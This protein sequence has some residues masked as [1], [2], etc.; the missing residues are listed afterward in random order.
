MAGFITK[1]LVFLVAIWSGLYLVSRTV[2]G[3][4]HE[5]VNTDSSQT[6]KNK[7]FDA[8]NIWQGSFTNTNTNLLEN[9]TW[10]APGTIGSATPNSG[11]FTSLTATDG[12]LSSLT[13]SGNF[14]ASSIAVTG[15]SDLSTVTSASLSNSGNLTTLTLVS[16]TSDNSGTQTTQNLVVLGN[17]A[18]CAGSTNLTVAGTLISGGTPGYYLYD[19]AGIL[20]ET[21]FA[22]PDWA[23]AGSIGATTPNSGVFTALTG[24]SLTDS[25]LTSGRVP[26]AG[27]GGL[28]SNHSAFTFDPTTGTLSS[29]QFSGVGAAV[30]GVNASQ[31]GGATFASPGAIGSGTP[32]SGS[33]T[34]GAFSGFVTST[35]AA[36]TNFTRVGPNQAVKSGG[37][38]SST[39]INTT[40]TTINLSTDGIT[41]SAQTIRIRVVTRLYSGTAAGEQ[42][43]GTTFYSDSGCTTVLNGDGK[44]FPLENRSYTLDTVAGHIY[45]GTYNDLWVHN[46]GATTIY[47]KKIETLNAGGTSYSSFLE[48]TGY[49]D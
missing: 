34:T 14:T 43:V 32:G 41:S 47:A 48:V 16:T 25:G 49:T 2:D 29:T 24:S 13:V 1:F 37:S 40:C 21:Q 22:T 3:Q 19:D 30:T 39:T 4:S 44:H 18:G 10:E 17:C 9:H 12:F 26:Y 28:L 46:A 35:K 33:F 36:V 7:T 6:L 5:Q 20:N 23:V 8:S 11:V 31:L 38:T 45:S 42:I 15:S 27:A